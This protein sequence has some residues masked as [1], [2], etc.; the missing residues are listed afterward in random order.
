M[1]SDTRIRRFTGAGPT[2]TDVTGGTS[3]LSASDSATPTTTNPL[4]VPPVSVTY[5]SY[6]ASFRLYGQNNA[7]TINNIRWYTDG[8][9]S[10][11]VG[12]SLTVG[13]SRTPGDAAV[14]IQATG[15]QGTTGDNMVTYSGT[16]H[17]IIDSQNAF[18]YT[19]ENPLAVPGS[20]V[21]GGGAAYFGDFVVIQIAV[22]SN[23]QPGETTD[24]PMTFKYDET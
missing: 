10:M 11:G 12:L 24:E 2:E 8:V 17:F 1:A 22:G 23:A 5:Y 13:R 7:G 14:Y 6:W 9:N 3:R 21:G 16:N 15:T 4:F 18:Q 20:F 19:S